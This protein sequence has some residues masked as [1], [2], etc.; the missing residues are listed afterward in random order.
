MDWIDFE[1]AFSS[2]RVGRYN[3][4]RVHAMWADW[5]HTEAGFAARR[6]RTSLPQ[7]A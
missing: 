1:T 7:P 5:K 4:S 2:A 6:E 3:L